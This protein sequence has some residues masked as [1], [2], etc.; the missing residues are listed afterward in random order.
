MRY[1]AIPETDGGAEIVFQKP[2]EN[3]RN[4]II[5][6]FIASGIWTARTA[7]I[8]ATSREPY[9]AA[10]SRVGFGIACVD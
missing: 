1:L 9:P 8:M 7:C 10:V 4:Q 3:R 5:L 2:E 6:L